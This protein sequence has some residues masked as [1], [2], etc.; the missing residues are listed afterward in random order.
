[1]AVPDFQTLMLP[2]LRAVGEVDATKPADIR[3]Y[4]AQACGLTPEDLEQRLP[5]GRQSTFENRC[6]WANV[7]L[8][9]AGLIATV[10]RGVYRLTERGR[11]VLATNPERIDMKY[12]ERF[13]EY[14]SWRKRSSRRETSDTAT[15]AEVAEAQPSQTPQEL[16]E[17]T[18]ESLTADLRLTLLD[19]VRTMSPSGFEGLIVDLLVAMGYGGG[20][21]EL[22]Q[23]T[24]ATN[25]GGIDGLIKEDPLGLDL[26]VMQAKRYGPGNSVGRPDVQS[27]AGSL[28][29]NNAT[30]GIFVTTSTFTAGAIDFARSIQKRLVLIDGDELTR[31]MVRHGVGVRVTQT[32]ELKDIDENVFEEG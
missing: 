28:D 31:L 30:K 5:S 21:A 23:Q 10:K 8:Q 2:V 9:R 6:A 27:F 17:S 11:E 26:V 4:V 25:D 20:R 13:P 19:R 24:R 32:F 14:T 16:I 22:A 1:M 7:F 29:G 15:I 12:L 18:I 3:A